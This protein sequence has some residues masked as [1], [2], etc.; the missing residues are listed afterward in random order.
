MLLFQ[1][2]PSY[3]TRHM[4][5]A[6]CRGIAFAFEIAS[7]LQCRDSIRQI[8]TT[9]LTPKDG[10]ASFAE[11]IGEVL[12]CGALLRWQDTQR[13]HFEHLCLCLSRLNN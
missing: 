2:P 9:L 7:L 6:L 13:V 8:A 1:P 10:G 4:E 3:L 12:R 11:R 5:A